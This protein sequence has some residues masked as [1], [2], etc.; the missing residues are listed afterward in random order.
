MDGAL[1]STLFMEAVQLGSIFQVML[2]H[3]YLANQ[4][5]G[6]PFKLPPP[7]VSFNGTLWHCCYYFFATRWRTVTT[8]QIISQFC[9]HL[10][11]SQE[12]PSQ[13]DQ[14]LDVTILGWFMGMKQHL[15]LHLDTSSVFRPLPKQKNKKKKGKANTTA[16][17]SHSNH[18]ALLSISEGH[19]EET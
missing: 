5:C 3:T 7:Q 15:L 4:V 14:S 19:E 6:F 1:A 10:Q 13:H 11:Q 8:E 2:L 9:T 12:Q 17:S 16:N 18:F